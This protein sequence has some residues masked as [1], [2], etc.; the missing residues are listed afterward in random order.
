M[1]YNMPIKALPE[2]DRPRERLFRDGAEALSDAEL[3]AIIIAVGNDRESSKRLAERL[4]ALGGLRYLMD[5]TVQELMEIRGI[6]KAK[7]AQIKSA[8]ELGLRLSAERVSLC[9]TVI[10]TPDDAANLL[11]T[12]MRYGDREEFRAILLNTKN[13]VLSI[14][15]VSIGTTNS[16]LAHPREMLRAALKHGAVA[17]ILAHNHPSGDPQPSP[18]DINVTRQ[19]KEAGSMVGITVLDHVVIGDGS[20]VSLKAQGMLKDIGGGR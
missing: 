14:Q 5:A 19:L 3:L 2:E 11:M 9:R 16:S 7:A 15:T 12:R 8:V 20:Y 6:G 13:Q 4:L 18:E 17:V 10:K 1:I